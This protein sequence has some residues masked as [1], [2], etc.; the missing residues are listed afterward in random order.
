MHALNSSSEETI[1]KS[2]EAIIDVPDRNEHFEDISIS[3]GGTILPIV[4]PNYKTTAVH[5][6]AIQESTAV[7]MKIVS[8]TPCIVQLIDASGNSVDGVADI[9]WQGYEEDV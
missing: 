1:V 8:R 2:L 7:S 4:T 9:S 6:D 5:L 3:A